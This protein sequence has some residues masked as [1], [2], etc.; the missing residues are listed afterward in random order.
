MSGYWNCNLEAVNSNPVL[1]AGWSRWVVPSVTLVNNQLVCFQPVGILNLADHNENSS[2]G[3]RVIVLPISRL[4]FSVCFVFCCC[5]CCFNYK[6]KIS[7][8][9]MYWLF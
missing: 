6:Q 4:C 9:W 2:A 1:I 7:I 3:L 8:F 5:C